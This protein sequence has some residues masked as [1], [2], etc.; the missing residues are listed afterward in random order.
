MPLTVAGKNRMLDALV[1]AASGSPIAYLSLHSG[2][3]NS[4]GSNELTGGSPAYARKS[5]A[6]SAAVSG[7]VSKDAGTPVF[8]VP[9]LTSVFFIGYW[10]AITAGTFL[11]YG[12]VNGGTVDGFATVADSG[13][14]ATSYAHGLATN[15]R[16]ILKAPPGGASLPPGLD[17]VT[18][19]W[20]VNAV[21]DTFQLS[22]TQGGSAITVGNG[23]MYFQKVI[24]ESFN[25]QG[26]F[27][28]SS[29]VI[30]LN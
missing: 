2:V 27:T 12:P 21:A 4:S 17:E 20:V 9:A 28:V 15:D 30:S 5:V 29:L 11:G 8:D 19:Y 13:D 25:S 7:D 23:E 16:T 14:T 1:G 22:L 24:G 18:I 3:P 26:T 10:T 6:W